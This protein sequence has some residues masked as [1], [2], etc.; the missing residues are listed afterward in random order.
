M[1]VKIVTVL[2]KNLEPG[3]ALNAAAHLALGLGA[4]AGK[5]PITVAAM[6]FQEYQDGDGFSYPG[7][8]ALSLIVLRATA[9]EIRRFH[10]AC[11]A[12]EMLTTAFVADM[13]GET[14]IEQLQRLKARRRED[15]VYYGVC[16]IGERAALDPMTKRFSL[17]K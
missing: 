8:S 1:P 16:S 3:I 6:A 12:S 2:N 14:Y 4:S 11:L 7:I 13:T 10:E 5:V 15:V 9:S 17:W